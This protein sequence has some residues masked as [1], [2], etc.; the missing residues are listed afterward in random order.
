M[1]AYIYTWYNILNSCLFVMFKAMEFLSHL[2][3]DIYLC[4]LSSTP[5]ILILQGTQD[6]KILSMLHLI[7]LQIVFF[8]K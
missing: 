3:P 4:Y 5:I 1:H 2:F 7:F 6:D 8:K